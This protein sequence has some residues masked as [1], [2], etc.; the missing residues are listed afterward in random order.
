MIEMSEKTLVVQHNAIVEARYKLTLEEQRVLKTLISQIQPNDE[1]FKGYEI[2]VLDL[3]RLIGI[4]E[5]YYYT[6]IK[7]LITKLRRSS[8]WFKNE[9]GDDVETGWLSS[10]TYR[11]GQGIVELRFDPVLK[12]YLLQL[13]SFFTSYE[14]GNILR[15]RSIYS[16]R[17]YELLKQYEKIGKREFSL[18][19]IKRILQIE[20][21]YKQYKDFKK[22]VISPATI[23][24]CEKTD[25]SFSIEEKKRGR[26]VI[27]FIFYI[28]S[29]KRQLTEPLTVIDPP[30]ETAIQPYQKPP[31]QDV[32]R[33]PLPPQDQFTARK[34]KQI[35]ILFD[36]GVAM[37][38]V[39]KL[40]ASFD[41][42]RIDQ[43]IA[44]TLEKQKDGSVKDVAA[45][46]IAA[47][48][49]DDPAVLLVERAA[50]LPQLDPLR[51]LRGLAFRI[52]SRRPIVLQIAL[53]E[54]RQDRSE[55]LDPGALR[56]LQLPGG[57]PPV[58]LLEL[59]RALGPVPALELALVAQDLRYLL[60]RGVETVLL[61]VMPRHPVPDPV[62]E[63]AQFCRRPFPGC[64]QLAPVDGDAQD[65]RNLFSAQPRRV[66]EHQ[67]CAK[68]ETCGAS[69]HGSILVPGREAAGRSP[70]NRARRAFPGC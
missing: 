58:E 16:V 5:E 18:D 6:R 22:S 7:L 56:R 70:E 3:A 20:N 34:Q 42:N 59:A 8:L 4:P 21:E 47:I 51:V 69:A 66:R 45:F 44:Y 68:A 40:L 49:R 24:I 62:V 13:K 25:I 53:R 15:L 30:K 46:V 2:R 32:P 65:A 41:P 37:F 61:D 11:K 29:K 43:G 50:H 52:G 63:P 26:K 36:M 33:S 19:E 28:T 31:K 67:N 38:T 9:N 48:E 1:D 12:P 60:L 17:I 55:L 64:R 57:K 10:A 14:L 54:A 27:G 23:E 35:E 39:E